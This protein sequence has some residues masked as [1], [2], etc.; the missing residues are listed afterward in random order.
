MF[1]YLTNQYA[2]TTF[3]LDKLWAIQFLLHMSTV[4]IADVSILFYDERPSVQANF[5]NL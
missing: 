5:F 2:G 1:N 4:I 3:K